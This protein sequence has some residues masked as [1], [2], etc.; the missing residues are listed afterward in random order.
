[1]LTE[2]V[3]Y[4]YFPRAYHSGG[5]VT[6]LANSE[7]A[8]IAT[9]RYLFLVPEREVSLGLGWIKTRRHWFHEAAT[10]LTVQGALERFLANPDLTIDQ[11]ETAL[12]D[13][14]GPG[15]YVVPLAGIAKLTVWS[16]FLR[17]V[18]FRQHHRR[19]TQV[20]ALRGKANHERFRDFYAAALT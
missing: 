13:L 2:G 12:R 15:E 5:A 4:L 6:G 11:V 9:Q 18:R 1:M 3:D 7:V 10:E 19:Q 20:L 17:Q 14:V 8:V 16:R